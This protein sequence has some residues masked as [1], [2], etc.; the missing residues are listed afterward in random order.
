MAQQEG[1]KRRKPASERREEV[2]RLRVT[3][4]QKRKLREAAKAAGLD[5]SAWIRTLALRE[6]DRMDRD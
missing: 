6:A 5:L 3:K 1:K 2:I 4:S